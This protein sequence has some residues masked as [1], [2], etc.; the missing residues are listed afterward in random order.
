MSAAGLRLPLPR[1]GFGAAQLGNLY[2]VTTDEEADGAVAA[3]WEQGIRCFDTAPH[4][5]IGTSERRL[6]ERLR[7]L[8]R[9]EYLV[10]TKVGR[11]L[12]PGPGTGDDHAN[13]FWVPDD[14][15]R[16]WDFSEVGVRASHQASL[17]RLGLDRVDILYAHD[18]EEGPTEQAFAEGLPA[19]A[20]MREEG[21][22]GAVGVGSK[23]AAVCTRA[24]RTGLVDLVMLSGRYTLLEQDAAR[25]LLDACLEHDVQVVAVSVF[26]SG[27]L[28]RPVVPDGATY[29]YAAAPAEI[30]AH[31]RA[32]AALAE[33]HGVTLPDLAVQYPLRHPAI[34]SVVLGMR[35]A[36]QVVSNVERMGQH[37]PEAAWE[38][39]AALEAEWAERTAGA[40]DA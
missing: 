21:L 30:L 33:D 2:R 31:A 19:L 25:E 16:R 13:A 17:E 37:V 11:L 34:A 29:E 35:T 12:D 5:G 38:A 20:R 40:R 23:D 36:G 32:L 14:H 10:S 7:G 39:V 6:G 4:Y 8:P 3:A 26:N 9:R 15:V 28:S 22:V 1:L 24:V 27:L 18:P